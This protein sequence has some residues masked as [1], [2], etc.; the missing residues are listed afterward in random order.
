VI[1][2]ETPPPSEGKK[3][4]YAVATAALTTLATALVTW[5]IDELKAKYAPKRAGK[6][7][8]S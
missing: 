4:A 3:L 2:D 5:G 8:A 6:D 1:L 7:E